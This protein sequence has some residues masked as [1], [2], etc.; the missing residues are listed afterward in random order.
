MG[1]SVGCQD[2]YMALIIIGMFKKQHNDAIVITNYN[3]AVAIV[4]HNLIN[5][6]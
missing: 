6:F 1:H 3:F 4:Q 2:D 5:K